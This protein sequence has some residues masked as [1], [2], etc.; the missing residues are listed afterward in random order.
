M[1]KKT[2]ELL[3]II[4]ILK[5]DAEALIIENDLVYQ[6]NDDKKILEESIEE[7]NNEIIEIKKKN[8]FLE[9]EKTLRDEANSD[10]DV[11]VKEMFEKFISTYKM[12]EMNIAKLS[13]IIKKIEKK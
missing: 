1:S 8:L 13:K 4:K 12:S 7:L 3:Q 10:D 11:N 9:N 5:T 6:C 2:D